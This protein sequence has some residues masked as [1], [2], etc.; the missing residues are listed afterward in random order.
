M[1][2]PHPGRFVRRYEVL[3][4]CG[5][6]APGQGFYSRMQA[7]GAVDDGPGG[8]RWGEGFQCYKSA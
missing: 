8:V 5:I 4:A 3:E 2:N 1:K 6:E 7:G